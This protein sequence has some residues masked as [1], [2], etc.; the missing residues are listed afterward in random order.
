MSSISGWL[1][2]DD[3]SVSSGWLGVSSVVSSNMNWL[4]V[5]SIFKLSW[6]SDSDLTGAAAGWPTSTSSAA[7][8][9]DDC[10]DVECDSRPSR[11]D[12]KLKSGLR[13]VLS[14]STTTSG[15]CG[16]A[17][18]RSESDSYFELAIRTGP[19][20]AGLRRKRGRL[21]RVVV[22]SSNSS[23]GCSLREY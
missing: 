19:T 3:V 15:G 18:R 9:D 10:D 20:T 17:G 12:S 5:T 8:D 22:V 4:G 2:V 7:S 21:S 23:G 14:E 11:R 6:E 1:L 16:T 13:L